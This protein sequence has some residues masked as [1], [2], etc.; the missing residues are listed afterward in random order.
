MD[1][2]KLPPE[3]KILIGHKLPVQDRARLAM[4]GKETQYQDIFFG[5]IFNECC[6]KP[7]N[8]EIMNFLS[9]QQ[10]LSKNPTTKHLVTL[11]LDHPFVGY[12]ALNFE[13]NN[14]QRGEP[15]KVLLFRKGEIHND[16]MKIS[17]IQIEKHISG[18]R[19]VWNDIDDH[20]LP[21]IWS[22]L[23]QILGNRLSCNK[24]L[25]RQGYAS[26]TLRDICF[27]EIIAQEFKTSKVYSYK[28]PY[29]SFLHTLYKILK[30]DTFYHIWEIIGPILSNEPDQMLTE[31]IQYKTTG[32]G[33]KYLIPNTITDEVHTKI[34][35][36][37][38]QLE[39][40]DLQ[41]F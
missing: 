4:A 36:M 31:V 35:E 3:L 20:N 18:Y 16:Y 33:Y 6:K 41:M 17:K 14:E 34:G 7:S 28:S 29:M 13:K 40:E 21:K 11:K 26:N 39:P 15:R 8:L 38:E 30:P 24:N 32:Q 27:L 10:T 19:M 9:Y 5:E 1:F 37:L 12:F 2:S 22:M 23:R 25:V